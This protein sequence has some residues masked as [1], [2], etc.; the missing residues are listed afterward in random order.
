MKDLVTPALP[1]SFYLSAAQTIKHPNNN[2]QLNAF[3]NTSHSIK[4]SSAKLH[5]S[6]ELRGCKISAYTHYVIFG[7]DDSFG[8]LSI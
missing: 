4:A 6:Y 2:Q 3:L 5:Q 8:I 1:E 7:F